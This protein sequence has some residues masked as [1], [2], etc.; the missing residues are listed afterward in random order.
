MSFPNSP[1]VYPRLT[2]QSYSVNQGGVFSGA[3]VVTAKRGSTDRVRTVTSQTEFY[4]I[5]G[6]PDKTVPSMYC[7]E[8]FLARAG[9]LHLKRVIVDAVAAT[10]TINQDA[11]TFATI[12][13]ENEGTWGN[14]VTITFEDISTFEGAGIMR[15]IIRENGLE[16]ERFTVSRDQGAKDGFGNALYVDDV[17]N[18]QSEYIRI[19]DDPQVAGSYPFGTAFTM[20]GGTD[21]TTAVDAGDIVNAWDSFNNPDELSVSVLINGG[22]TTTAVQVKILAIAEE[23]GDCHAILD[24]PQADSTDVAAMITH[25]QST[26]NADSRFGSIYGGWLRIYDPNLDAEVTIPPSGDVAAVYGYTIETAERWVAPAGT[27]YGVI[28]NSLGVSKVFTEGER[29]LLY[30]AGINPVTSFAGSAAIVWGQKTLRIGQ[31]ATNRVNVANLLTWSSVR[32]KESLRPFVFQPNTNQTRQS[33]NFL[34]TS[35]W[36]S[37]K[38]RG[39]VYDYS[40]NT[41]EDI[42]TAT[43][44]DANQVRIQ[45]YIQPTRA[46]EFIQ[47]ETVVT[48]TGV[49]FTTA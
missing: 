28:P 43:V 27:Q 19:A 16:V 42:N 31:T 10:G 34:L 1:G 23:R 18:N 45:V 24:V 2:N 26:L 9:I 37:I 21:D 25:R 35:F 11:S 33:I 36:E 6:Y 39:G 32:M 48:S 14:N 3:I 8:R 47:V 20:T 49:T 46:A 40:V 5:F 17:I 15:A 41:G 30:V 12:T 13:A 22:F 4:N 44:I 7:A 38:Q 29:D